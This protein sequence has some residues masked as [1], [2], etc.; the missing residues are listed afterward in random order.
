[1][2]LRAF[3]ST[4]RARRAA[5]VAPAPPPAR[6][7]VPH[8]RAVLAAAPADARVDARDRLADLAQAPGLLG[9]DPE[10]LGELFLGGVAPELDAQGVLGPPEPVQGVHDVGREPHGAR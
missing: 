9:P 3:I 4:C 10:P 7:G 5:R 2:V 1:M 6:Q 8:R